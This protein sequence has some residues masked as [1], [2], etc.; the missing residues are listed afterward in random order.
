MQYI[1]IQK[2][3]GS[4]PRKLRLVADMV[5]KMSPDQA[6]ETLSFT[7]KSAALPLIKAIKTAVANAGKK[8][9]LNFASLEVNEGMKMKRFRSA[10]R[11]RVRPYKKRFSHIKVVLTDELTI[12]NEQVLSSQKLRNKRTKEEPFR[13]ETA[14]LDEAKV[15]EAAKVDIDESSASAKATADKKELKGTDEEKKGEK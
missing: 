4:S 9:G 7:Q 13:V 3:I 14:G 8:D 15:V 5:R 2:N 1:H 10:A 12:N 6:I 11:G